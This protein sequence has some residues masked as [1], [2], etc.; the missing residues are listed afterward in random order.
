MHVGVLVGDLDRAM[1]FYH[2]I[3]GFGE[4]WRGS[5]SET[6][7]NWVNMRAPD[8]QD[9]LEFMLYSKLPAPGDR[10]TPHHASL[11]IANAEGALAALKARA[12]RAG[13]TREITI[14]TGINRKRH[15]DLYDPDGTRIELMEANT[16][17]GKPAPS[18]QAPPPHPGSRW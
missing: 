14:I 5:R 16:V 13:Y 18:S 1:A 10:G 8:G 3:L 12:A 4:F 15:I 2:G 7:L 17:D 11:T 9:Y 6:E